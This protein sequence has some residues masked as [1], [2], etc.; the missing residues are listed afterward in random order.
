[1]STNDLEWLNYICHYLSQRIETK[2]KDKDKDKINKNKNKTKEEN[3]HSDR[4]TNPVV[5]VPFDIVRTLL[6]DPESEFYNQWAGEIF[7]FQINRVL[8]A[9]CNDEDG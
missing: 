6:T 8:R 9:L 7:P 2:D 5:M 4:T 3:E 1:M